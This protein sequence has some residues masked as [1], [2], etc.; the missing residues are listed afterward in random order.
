MV[1]QIEAEK[2]INREEQPCSLFSGMRLRAL[3]SLP[4][5]GFLLHGHHERVGQELE[6]LVV[7]ARGR[8]TPA[9]YM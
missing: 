3:A 1:M 2:E 6:A 7:R 4:Y 8:A 5:L 9:T